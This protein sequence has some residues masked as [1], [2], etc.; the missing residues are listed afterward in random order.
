MQSVA[1]GR[2]TCINS[3][4]L[5]FNR[6]IVSRL[7][8]ARADI[9]RIALSAET[10]T[11]WIGRVL[12]AMTI[13][14]GMKYLG[15]TK[16]NAAER[17]LP[18]VFAIDDTAI[19]ELTDSLM[20]VWVS[21]ALV[22][23][24]TVTSAVTNGTFATDITGWTDND[25]S[26]ATS[27]WAS[28]S[29][30]GL[31]G[32]GTAAAIRDQTVTVGAN[33]N[34]EHALRVDVYRGPVYIRVGTSTTDDSYVAE[35]AL[36]TGLHS[37][38]FT[39]TGDFNI[40]LF[41]R[42]TQPKYVNSCTVESAGVMEIAT[43]WTA[44]LLDDVRVDQSGDILFCACPG[45]QQ[46]MIERRSSTSWSI[47]KYQP[48]DGPFRNLN[49]GPITLTPG[50]LNGNT[51]LTASKALFKSTQAGAMFSL[52]SVGQRVESDISAQ[53]TF[54]NA[55]RISGL[56]TVSG[57]TGSTGSDLV[58][59][60]NDPF[61]N[62]LTGLG[63]A[64]TTATPTG[65]TDSGR[66][67]TLVIAGTWTG[68]VTVQRSLESDTGP[69]ED[70][71]TTYAANVTTTID[72]G[73]DNQIVWYR[74]GVKTGDYGSGTAEISLYY[75]LG[76]ITG[77]GRVTS[78]S[79][80]TVV[81]VDV[82]KD[83]GGLTASDIWAE[84]AWSD[85]R[86]WPSAVAFHEGRLW[87]AGKSG[88]WGSVSDAYT[89]FDANVVGDSGPIS[90][91]LASG[92]VDTINWLLSSQ[93]LIVGAQGAEYAARSSSLDEPLTPTAFTV[94]VTSSQ[95]SAAVSPVEIDSSVVFV[96][97]TGIRVFENALNAS[98]YDYALRDLSQLV[99]DIGSPG[100]V[101]MAIQRQPDT[102]IHCVRSDGT[103]AICVID[104]NEEVICWSTVETDGDVEDVV[105]MPAASG[106][107]D[108]YVYY[109]V[110]RT[111]NGSTV[112]YLE[113]WAQSDTC[114]G[115]SVCNLADSYI[116]YTS[117]ATTSITGLSHL[118]GESVVVWANGADVG[119]T[120]AYGQTYT[121]ASGAI[122]LATAATNV[123]VGLP[124]TAQY[125]SAKLG[126]EAQGPGS[127]G[128]TKRITSIWLI[129]ADTHAKGVRFGPDFTHLDDRPERD[130]WATTDSDN[131]DTAYDQD[132]ILFPA[133]W[134]ADLRLCLQAQAPRPATILAVALDMESK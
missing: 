107:L 103:V 18:F 54:T 69:W 46:R 85:Y 45:I 101:R 23:R 21:D 58:S 1:T 49:T 129:L 44:A 50:A 66:I 42:S 95:G 48:D 47:V 15:A 11:N 65:G 13:R 127:L 110:K 53:N 28:S 73:L 78:F 108:D 22:T 26:G 31:T 72:D 82:V 75:A 77:Y 109:V 91:T 111:I 81:Y 96:N 68:T 34:I 84:S 88:L 97:R 98:T 105:V 100:I 56:T 40:R 106:V 83:F 117:T 134:T 90:R 12:G 32:D 6:G 8:L 126:A 121:V 35:T 120:S 94:K 132:S 38:T 89:T 122:T 62:Q 7:A 3:T 25:E 59:V 86:G 102:R 112:R 128:K 93:R 37:L 17:M 63:S 118:E 71:T 74:A 104:K 80:S 64:T 115:A 70:V 14:P 119:T 24:P 55:I 39:P 43:P 2:E 5:N 113:K 125:K 51:T 131:V 79:S 92:P 52:T 133:T 76:S 29:Y 61:F 124:Y 114:Y 99:P 4:L 36:G 41:S 9:K 16:S 130:E 27:A 10:M 57:V 60:Y 20:R 30:M 116:N 87:W 33:A 123:T 67:F 19:V